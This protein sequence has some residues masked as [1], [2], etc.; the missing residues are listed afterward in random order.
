MRSFQ[1]TNARLLRIRCT[2][3]VCTTVCGNTE[4][5]A[6]GKPFSPSTTAIRM[7][8]TPRASSSLTTLSQNLAPSVCSIQSPSTLLLA[9]RIERQRHVDGLV[10]DQALVADFDPQSVEKHHRIDRIE[11]PVL[12]FPDLIK[13]RIGHPADQVG[14]DLG[15]IEF[16]QV[17]LDLAHRHA[18][19]VKAQDLVVEAVEPGLALADQLRLEAAGPVARDRNLDL[20]VLGQYR[21]RTRAVAA[22]AAAAAGRIALLVAQDARSA[23]RRAPARSGPSLAA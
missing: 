22:V 10:L 2:M 6:S 1:D 19:R 21:L 3:Q 5:I 13:H 11:R 9:V 16:G 12:P 8:L 17:A 20:P 23:P 18:A 15:A 4:V 14:R 7:S